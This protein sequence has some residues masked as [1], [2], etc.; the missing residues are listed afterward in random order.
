MSRII[1]DICG[2]QNNLSIGIIKNHKGIKE[3]H[4]WVSDPYTGYSY[5]PGIKSNGV[6]IKNF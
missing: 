3:A 6:L 5:T 1:L 4:A 2:F